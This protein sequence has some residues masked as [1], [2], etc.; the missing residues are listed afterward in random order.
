MFI[1]SRI[2]FTLS[3]N[4][5]EIHVKG[6]SKLGQPKYV[7]VNTWVNPKSISGRPKYSV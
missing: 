3:L 2:E 1:D 6:G 7:N 4:R 5:S